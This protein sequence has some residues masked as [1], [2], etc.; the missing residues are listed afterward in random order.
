MKRNSLDN[1]T[2]KRLSSRGEQEIS[3]QFHQTFTELL[4]PSTVAI[5]TASLKCDRGRLEWLHVLMAK[6]MLHQLSVMLRSMMNDP[7]IGS[8]VILGAQQSHQHLT[9]LAVSFVHVFEGP[10]FCLSRM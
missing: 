2:V 4:T 1:R 10:M 3:T 9:C 6:F 8:V 7:W 5:G